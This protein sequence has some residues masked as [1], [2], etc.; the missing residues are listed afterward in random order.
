MKKYLAVLGILLCT[1]HAANADWCKKTGGGMAPCDTV[2]STW[3]NCGTAPDGQAIFCYPTGSTK[4]H[5]KKD[6]NSYMVLASVGVGV[7]FVGAMYYFFKKRP[8]E[9][10]PGQVTLASF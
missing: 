6:K 2:P 7:I 1:T 10:N 4:S 9:N 5:A 8:S 3:T